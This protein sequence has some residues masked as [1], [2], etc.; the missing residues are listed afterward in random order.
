MSGGGTTRTPVAAKAPP[1]AKSS[2][3][4][5]SED[6]GLKAAPE[7]Q[8]T[9]WDFISRVGRDSARVKW[10]ACC[11]WPFD[12]FLFL[13]FL[14]DCVWYGIWQKG[15]EL[16]GEDEIRTLNA[17]QLSAWNPSKRKVHVRGTFPPGGVKRE[18]IGWCVRPSVHHIGESPAP[19]T[20]KRGMLKRLTQKAKRSWMTEKIF[21]HAH[22]HHSKNQNNSCFSRSL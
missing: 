3:L 9:T 22:F 2:L 4:A 10:A 19:N 16:T 8:F 20:L 12:P 18:G 13:F 11:R 14:R 1:G 7:P 5:L 21:S 17:A 15:S 6:D